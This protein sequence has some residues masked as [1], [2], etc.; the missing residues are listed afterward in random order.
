MSKSKAIKYKRLLV[1]GAPKSG[2]TTL[3]NALRKRLSSYLQV[4]DTNF[5][6]PSLLKED[7]TP[8]DNDIVISTSGFLQEP[9]PQQAIDLI[10]DYVYSKIKKTHRYEI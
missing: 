8:K 1:T 10:A 5:H 4:I 6:P 7:Y 9:D 3:T 2:V